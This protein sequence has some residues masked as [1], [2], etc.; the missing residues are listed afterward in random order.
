VAAAYVEPPDYGWGAVQL[1]AT[2]LRA[3]GYG[4]DEQRFIGSGVVRLLLR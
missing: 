4:V 1:L 2:A 3:L